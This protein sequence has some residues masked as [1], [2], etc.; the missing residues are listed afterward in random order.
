MSH[1]DDDET[2]I[3]EEEGAWW[4]PDGWITRPLP[5]AIARREAATEGMPSLESCGFYPT[6]T[7]GEI[8]DDSG[9]LEIKIHTS[10][11][12]LMVE[13]WGTEA[14]L[15]QFFVGRWHQ[16]QFYADKLPS[17]LA[18]YGRWIIDPDARP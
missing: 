14:Q 16:V 6:I 8:T 10:T 4:T 11:R 2:G 18:G 3:T 9:F 7:F 13:I 5:P 15:A 1:N 17:L 12:V